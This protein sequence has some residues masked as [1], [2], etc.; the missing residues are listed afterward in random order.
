MST[1][2][3]AV[4]GSCGAA[5]HLLPLGK[6]LLQVLSTQQNAKTAVDGL[7]KMVRPST[8]RIFHIATA[9]DNLQFVEEVVPLRVTPN[10]AGP[11][12]FASR[13]TSGSNDEKLA[14]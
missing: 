7:Y 10:L 13:T 14:R 4:I 6:H 9:A 5:E 12:P 3:V 2:L 11:A 1:F 8:W